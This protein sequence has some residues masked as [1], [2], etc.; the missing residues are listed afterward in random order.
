MGGDAAAP[1]KDQQAGDA[2]FSLAKL[3]DTL[4][5][6]LRKSMHKRQAM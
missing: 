3:D 5:G 2:L 4:S 1:K 6:K